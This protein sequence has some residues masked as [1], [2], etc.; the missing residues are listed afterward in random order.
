VP[1]LIYVPIPPLFVIYALY[2]LV[3]LGKSSLL[4]PKVVSARSKVTLLKFVQ[5]MNAL[6]PMLVTLLPIVTLVKLLHS[7]NA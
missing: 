3:P 2:K 1:V 5:P 7:Q 4:L 6:L